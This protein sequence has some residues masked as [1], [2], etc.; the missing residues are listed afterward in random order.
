MVNYQLEF[1]FIYGGSQF[2]GTDIFVVGGQLIRL[3]VRDHGGEKGRPVSGRLSATR[4]ETLSSSAIYVLGKDKSDNRIEHDELNSAQR[5][6]PHQLF[7]TW[8]ASCHITLTKYGV[9]SSAGP[10]NCQQSSPR[11][12]SYL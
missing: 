4:K 6:L 8:L 9:S 3:V 2:M 1:V 12:R 5:E 7:G 10:R 11:R